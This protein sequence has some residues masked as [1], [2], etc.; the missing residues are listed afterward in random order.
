LD[1]IQAREMDEN[2]RQWMKI[3]LNWKDE[4]LNEFKFIQCPTFQASSKSILN[5]LAFE[6]FPFHSK[7]E[8]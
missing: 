4:S 7:D 5:K 2:E 6:L 3:E 8:F 1:D